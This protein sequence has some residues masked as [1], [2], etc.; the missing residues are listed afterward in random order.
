MTLKRFGVSVPED[1]L[2]KF[3]KIVRQ[4]EYV[5]RSEA[6]RDAMRGYISQVEL[7]SDQ[8]GTVASLNIVYRHKPRLMAE[9]MKAQHEAHI[10]VVSTIHVHVSQSHCLEVITLKGDKQ[11]IANMAN[12]I[13]GL[14]G[15]EYVRLFSFVL[16]DDESV[17]YGH[18]H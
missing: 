1:L 8:E 2:E 12:K 18:S 15:I 13:S 7:E 5:G 4:K 10:N 14:K 17:E 3:D 16:Q 9:L 11:A 6:I